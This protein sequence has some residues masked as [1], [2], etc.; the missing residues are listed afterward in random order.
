MENTEE[1]KNDAEN[2]EKEND[3]EPQ[4]EAVSIVCYSNK[5]Y[6]PVFWLRNIHV[7]L[8]FVS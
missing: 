6:G 3:S 2:D 1:V 5:T 8:Y 7:F 4:A